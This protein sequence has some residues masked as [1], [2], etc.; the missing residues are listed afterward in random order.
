M[1]KI[2][3]LLVM[4]LCPAFCWS[5]TC[6][7]YPISSC[8]RAENVL[9]GNL[10]ALV[11]MHGQAA[12]YTFAAGSVSVRGAAGNLLVEGAG[13]ASV[14]Y[15]VTAAT[16]VTTDTS[17]TSLTVGGG[18]TAGTGAVPVVGVTGKLAAFNSTNYSNLSGANLTGIP[19]TAITAGVLGAGNYTV[20]GVVTVSTPAVAVPITPVSGEA[21]TTGKYQVGVGGLYA[22]IGSVWLRAAVGS[23]ATPMVWTNY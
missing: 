9:D 11:I 7:G 12:P 8:V 20:A 6:T 3:M 17:A 15:S 18:I 13:G 5:S 4:L 22:C 10:G 21:C 1:L 2:A 16:M 14:T 19:A 23:N